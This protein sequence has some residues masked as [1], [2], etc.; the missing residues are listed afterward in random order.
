MCQVH[1]GIILCCGPAADPDTAV[2]CR[3]ESLQ[4]GDTQPQSA[5]AQIRQMCPDIHTSG[6]MRDHSDVDGIV[7]MT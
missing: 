5:H 1:M 7:H 2:C 4:Q 3:D 6:L